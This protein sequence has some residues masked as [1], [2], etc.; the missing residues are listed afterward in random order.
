MARRTSSRVI[1]RVLP[2]TATT[3]RLLKPLMWAPDSVRYTESISMPAV[4]SASSI[5]FL[6]D[7]T[8]SSRFTTAPRRMPL[9]SAVPIPMISTPPSSVTSPTIAATL[10]VPTSR[11]TR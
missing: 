7:S 6:I 3:P 1:S 10:V 8:A 5:A 4:S 11:P 9:A 2:E